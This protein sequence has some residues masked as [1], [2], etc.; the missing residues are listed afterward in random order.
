MR[1]YL[2]LQSVKTAVRWGHNSHAT[3]FQFSPSPHWFLHLSL[4]GGIWW[5]FD[6]LHACSFV[7]LLPSEL[8][9]LFGL[10]AGRSRVKL[11]ER[12]LGDNWAIARSTQKFGACNAIKY[13]CHQHWVYAPTHVC[14]T[15]EDLEEKKSVCIAFEAG[16][17]DV[18]QYSRSRW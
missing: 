2:V 14:V 7:R 11:P 16:I 13:D 15:A 6:S 8:W 10:D 9:A 17:K 12:Q 5:Y 3:D 4:T 1:S 18:M